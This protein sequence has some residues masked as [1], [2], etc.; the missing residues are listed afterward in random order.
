[1]AEVE[2][3]FEREKWR[4]IVNAME[5]AGAAKYTNSFIQKKYDE[6]SKTPTMFDYVI[7]EESSDAFDSD[8]SSRGDLIDIIPRLQQS[9]AVSTKAR[10]PAPRED[11]NGVSQ[12]DPAQSNSASRMTCYVRI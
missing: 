10:I 8:S 1:M 9:G 5:R 3:E 2:A 4:L 7:D 12:A 6:L 11:S